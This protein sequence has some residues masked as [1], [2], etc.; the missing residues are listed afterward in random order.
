[1][2]SKDTLIEIPDIDHTETDDTY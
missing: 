2:P 1:V